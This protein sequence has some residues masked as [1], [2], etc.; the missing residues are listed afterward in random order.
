M[1]TNSIAQL[2]KNM[3]G[4]TLTP[5]QQAAYDTLRSFA[6]ANS[7]ASMAVLTGYA[8]TGK[9]TLVGKLTDELNSS[10]HIAVCAP[11]NKAVKVLREKI[12]AS[13]VEFATLH[14]L[15]GLRMKEND[16][17]QM[18]VRRE[19][20]SSLHEY[21]LVV[22]D[23]C[24]MISPDL[25]QMILSGKRN[26]R[27]LFVGDPAQLPPVGEAMESPVFSMVDLRA[28]LSE[29][30]RQARGNPI[31]ELSMA[32]RKSMGE[33]RV[34]SPAEITAALPPS[35][36][37]V[38]ACVTYGGEATAIQ[39]ALAE[40]EAKRECRIIAFTNAQVQQYNF[41]IHN[42]LHGF[43]SWLFV[44]GQKLMM[45]EA[46]EARTGGSVKPVPLH[47]S[48]ELD[49]LSVEQEPHPRYPNI[50]ARRLTLM[51]DDGAEVQG[52]VPEDPGALQR[53]ISDKFAEW[54]AL[55]AEGRAG[56]IEARE[57]AKLASQQAWGMKKAFL[58]L[59]HTYAITAHKSQGSTFDTVLVDYTNL[60]RMRSAYE[61]NRALYVAITRP[62]QFLAV[63]A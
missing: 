39:W 7:G 22:V 57:K 8:G 13:G 23:E 47:T 30:V 52:Y 28:P 63:V 37:G 48:E 14:S 11:T 3:T 4:V 10:L 58:P 49:V 45:Q 19:G 61:L 34:M 16:D 38:P 59:R 31:I 21:N 41:Q 60:C 35:G 53:E 20:S 9:T 5:H 50:Q 42:A 36:Q 51:R 18:D 24:S 15:L 54:R 46:G 55:T 44:S 25:F 12:T 6:K 29:V 32:I 62:S 1:T 26:A 33:N 43:D 17:G 56:N 2:V 40:I 27:V